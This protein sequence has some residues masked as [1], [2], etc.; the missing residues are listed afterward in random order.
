MASSPFFGD[1]YVSA[2]YG[3]GRVALASLAAYGRLA[4]RLA[5]LRCFDVL[6]IEKELA[7]FLPAGLES[8]LLGGG[9][10]A[11]DMDD[12]WF[13]RYR[14]H[15]FAPIRRFLGEKF[16]RLARGAA[17]VTAANRTIEQWA[18]RAGARMVLGLPTVVDIARYPLLPETAEPFTIGWIGTPITAPYLKALA[19]PLA[20]LAAEAP[21]KLLIIGAPQL[22]LSGVVCEHA[23]W[24]EETE[25]AL[26]A[27]C[28]VG[29]M[30]LPDEPWTRAKSGYK[31]IQY[32][33]AGRAAVASPL[34]A[35]RDI[36]G[37][38]E[39][40]LFAASAEEWVR[41]LR[42][43]RDDPA[44]RQAMG[45]AARARAEARFSLAAHA[46]RLIAALQALAEAR[47]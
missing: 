8:V 4:R 17:L 14:E 25:A 33:A 11:L 40:G 47:K 42:R 16:E 37:E 34:G 13:L 24:R 26:I 21:L 38:G 22:S 44:L 32:M 29:V 3:G 41:T 30:P 23:P 43:L 9:T 7:P 27:R 5:K 45:A 28:H 39:T 6:W 35:N 15:R 19:T 31:L 2:L 36:L 12:A 46:P 20:L 10:Y 1:S 18:E